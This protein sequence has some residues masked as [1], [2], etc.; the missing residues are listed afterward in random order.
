[1]SDRYRDINAD[2]WF[3]RNNGYSFVVAMEAIDIAYKDIPYVAVV[4]ELA[5]KPI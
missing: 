2:Y 1:M 4:G 5:L 3:L